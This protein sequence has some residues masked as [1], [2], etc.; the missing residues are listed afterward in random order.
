MTFNMP[1]DVPTTTLIP[2]TSGSIPAWYNP[3]KVYFTVMPG[4]RDPVKKSK[5]AAG[6]DLFPMT[7]AVIG[8]STKKYKDN[9]IYNRVVVDTGVKVCIP[10]GHYGRLATRS[11]TAALGVQVLGGVI[12]QDYRGTIKVILLNS[13]FH[14]RYM[15][16]PTIAIAQLIIEAIGPDL[17]YIHLND[18]A[19]LPVTQRDN[20]G[21][22]STDQ[23][24]P[25]NILIHQAYYNQ[26]YQKQKEKEVEQKL[27]AQINHVIQSV[28]NGH[29]TIHGH[30]T[31]LGDQDRYGCPA[32]LPGVSCWDTYQASLNI[33]GSN[34]GC[35]S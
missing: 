11:S 9:T 16:K 31:Y 26:E 20:Q 33:M 28:Y 21:F 14:E 34:K 8:T 27:E 18:Y 19:L 2:W 13:S 4:A 25:A 1:A 15:V 7:D 6:W 23:K 5:G 10:V 17:T 32:A 29:C 12:D 22:G 35:S 3:Y 24:D 30:Y